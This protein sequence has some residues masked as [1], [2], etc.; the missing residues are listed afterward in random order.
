MSGMNGSTGTYDENEGYLTLPGG[1]IYGWTRDYATF[2]FDPANRDISEKRVQEKQKMIREG[3]DFLRECPI[4]VQYVDGRLVI[5]DGQHR[6]VAAEREG[7]VLYYI[8]T[9]RMD[10]EDVVAI[11]N[12]QHSWSV[13]D[14]MKHFLAQGKPEY[15]AL[16]AFMQKYPWMLAST[17]I[18]LCHYG[19]RA[20]MGFDDGTYT[21]NDLTFAEEVAQLCLRFKDMTPA[22]NTRSFTESLACCLEIEGFDADRL[23]EKARKQ[24]GD[25][26]QHGRIEQYM[27][28]WDQIYNKYQKEEFVLKLEKV[29][30][31]SK[32]R[33]ADRRRRLAG[34]GR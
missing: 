25:I 4:I 22:W 23:V 12:S 24:M 13:H 33:R 30:S 28:Q 7:V 6:R 32:R 34:K 11:N 17:A 26:Q 10:S 20:K 21:A 19:D 18:N 8:L 2:E 5:R 27:R 15:K 1:A 9:D 31:A 29:N 14:R 3:K 16:A